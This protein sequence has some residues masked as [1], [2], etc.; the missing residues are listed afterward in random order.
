MDLSLAAPLYFCARGHGR[1]QDGSS[2]QTTARVL[3]S[4]LG[5]DEQLGGYQRHRKAFERR[6]Y[7]GLQSEVCMRPNLAYLFVT[8]VFSDRHG[9]L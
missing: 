2:A 5:A 9:R 3:L 6:G 7:E 8:Q 1:L 4:G